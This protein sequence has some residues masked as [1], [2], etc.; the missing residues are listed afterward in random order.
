MKISSAPPRQLHGNSRNNQY[1]MRLTRRMWKS[2]QAY[3][4]LVP[5]FVFLALFKYEPFI[6]AFIKSLYEWNG[7]NVNQFVGLDNFYRMLSDPSFLTSLKNVVFLT[8]GALLA[9]I[10]LPLI[11]AVMVYHLKSKEVAHV[12]RVLFILPLV[13]PGIVVIRIWST[14][15]EQGGALN[16]LLKLVGL[17]E[18]THAWLGEQGTAL[19]SLIFYN[20]PWIGGIFFLLYMAGLMAIPGDLFEAGS[21]DGMT[22]WS[23]FWRLELPMLKSQIKLVVMLTVISQIQNFELPLILTNGGPGDASLTPALHLYN[24]AFTHN[25]L[26]YASA[27]GVVLF[28][29]I[30][31]LT[32]INNKFLKATESRD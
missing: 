7:A 26:G 32:V 29:V 27:I 31:L 17:G 23:R 4:F 25:E 15:Y 21:M 16:Q 18:Y 6:I 3:Y 19:G 12:V 1:T 9:N 24:R 28:L 30:L 10:T 14:I 8:I 20:F 11:A 22:R 13:V 5:I 2:R